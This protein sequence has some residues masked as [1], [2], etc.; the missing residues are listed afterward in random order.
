M[1]AQKRRRILVG[2]LAVASIIG[3]SL[4]AVA[5]VARAVTRV[6]EGTDRLLVVPVTLDGILESID[7]SCKVTFC[8][9]RFSKYIPAACGWLDVYRYFRMSTGR[10]GCRILWPAG[11][12]GCHQ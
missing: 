4:G 2:L 12:P 9:E 6:R 1:S 3:L 7:A 8:L 10:C 5:A 11:G